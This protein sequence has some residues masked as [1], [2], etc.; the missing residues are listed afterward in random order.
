MR[1]NLNHIISKFSW[2]TSFD[3]KEKAFELQER[4][5]GWS[6]FVMPNEIGNV[7]NKVCPPDQTWR[8]QSLEIDLGKIDFDSLEFELSAK[9][10]NRLY[11]KLTDLIVY[12][13]RSG[14]NIEILNGDTSHIYMIRG[15]LLT[16]LMPWGYKQTDGTV[17]QML[18]HQLQSNRQQVVAMLKE[19][20][21]THLNVR[22]RLA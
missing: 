16:G 22:K 21:V 10:R 17:N 19:V 18:Y 5:S 13:N 3:R 6:R 4:L 2:D 14:K 15:F 11:E 8:I 1:E 9:L 20:G 7:F 12:A